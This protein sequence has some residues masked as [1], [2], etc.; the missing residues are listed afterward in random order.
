MRVRGIGVDIADVDRM[1]RLLVARGDEFTRKWFHPDEIADCRRRPDTSRAFAEHFAVKEAVWK[2]LGADAWDGPLAWRSIV[3]RRG[4]P[5]SVVLHGR[6]AA[7]A[8]RAGGGLA[9]HA[10]VTSHAR[11]AVAT[12]IVTDPAATLT[13]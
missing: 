4:A 6:A 8:A 10:S 9:I 13:A 11:I 7:L 1:A 3:Y 12:V 5:Q 2:A